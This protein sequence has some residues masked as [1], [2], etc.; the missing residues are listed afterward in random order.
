MS[1]DPD[2]PAGTRRRVDPVRL[3]AGGAA[4]MIVAAGVGFVGVLVIQAIFRVP[5]L[6]KV[7]AEVFALD[8]ISLAISAAIAAL[9]A[10]GVLHLLMVSTPRA[11]TFFAWIMSLFV[12]GLIVQELIG[13]GGW[14]QKILLSALYL[15]IAVAITS[16]L[17]GVGRTAIKYVS[18]HPHGRYAEPQRSR[19][20][21][22]YYDDDETRR[23][24]PSY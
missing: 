9:L 2:T 11:H 22:G 16:L 8:Q 23:L 4:T 17:T 24:P 15:V 18:Y 6:H 12:L 10:T 1:Y 5:G 21:D 7:G 3:W 13:G 19:Y 14:L 20:R